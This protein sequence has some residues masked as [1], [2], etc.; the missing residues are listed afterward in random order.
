MKEADFLTALE[1]MGQAALYQPL[2]DYRNLLLKWNKAY[3]LTAIK[4]PKEI[5][6]K[7]FIDSLAVLPWLRG[8]R[9]IDIGTGAGLPGIPLALA[10]P[11]YHFVLLDAVGKKI[12][13]LQEVKRTLALDNLELIHGRVEN[14]HPSLRFDT[15]TSRAFSAIPQFIS[16]TEHL[17]HEHGIWLAMKGKIPNEELAQLRY[18]Y[19]VHP[20]QIAEMDAERC[21]III[22]YQI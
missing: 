6:V 11:D 22:H 7:H 10:R 16:W 8:P 5:L 3:N 13:F 1:N 2:L 17:I 9:I 20:Y 15:L 4:D 21:C 14:Y 19:Q 12:N 18:P